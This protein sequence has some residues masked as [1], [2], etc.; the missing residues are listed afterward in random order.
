MGVARDF[1]LLVLNAR[2]FRR[3]GLNPR[4]WL[5]RRVNQS[6]TDGLMGRWIDDPNMP[7]GFFNN[8][9]VSASPLFALRSA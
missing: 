3:A 6:A 1:G 9:N 7:S 5:A 8:S 2:E 4:W